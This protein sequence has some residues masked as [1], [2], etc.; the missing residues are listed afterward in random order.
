MVNGDQGDIARLDHLADFDQ[1][2][3]FIGR[4]ELLAFE[5]SVEYLYLKGLYEHQASAVGVRH[6][7]HGQHAHLGFGSG[8]GISLGV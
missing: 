2:S 3:D 1:W 4:G 6:V 5:R 8:L 7:F